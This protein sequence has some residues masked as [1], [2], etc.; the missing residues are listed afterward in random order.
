MFVN[1]LDQKNGLSFLVGLLC[2][3]CAVAAGCDEDDALSQE[4]FVE[5]GS[6]LGSQGDMDSKDSQGEN[7]DALE[8]DT[9]DGSDG[10]EET[11]DESEETQQEPSTEKDQDTETS[12]PLEEPQPFSFVVITDTHVRLPGNP[13]DTKY[14]NAE[15]LEKL[16]RAVEKINGEAPDAAFVAVTGDLV[17]CLFSE[18]PDDYLQG[19]ENPAEKFKEIMDN[20]LMPY[21][22]ALGNHDYEIDFVFG[23]GINAKDPS[24]PEAVWKKVLGVDPYYSFVYN[25]TRFVFLNSAR[26]PARQKTCI[27]S[28]RESYCTGSFDEE[29]IV[30]LESQLS[31]P[32]PSYLF[33][34]HPPITDHPFQAIWSVA[35]PS[36][37][38]EKND[39]FYDV[40]KDFKQ[41]I[42][43]IFV[44]HGHLWEYDTLYNAIDVY[45]TG[46]IGDTLS[47]SNNIR[48]V[49]VDPYTQDFTVTRL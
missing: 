32:E 46:S 10:R 38:V 11:E 14:A 1:A 2:G 37:Q 13:D 5:I 42:S 33:F 22:V 36:F 4:D 16:T 35:G 44:G 19:E 34:H 8:V 29:Q 30:W 49:D 12:A 24:G 45:E 18:D 3:V 15:N 26:G 41:E 21:Y 6:D 9:H 23:E 40:A 39:E 31:N 47:N 20:L 48:L 43:A 27:G 7:T 17:G 25:Q 28:L